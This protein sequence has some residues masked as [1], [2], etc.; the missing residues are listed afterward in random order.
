MLTI[1][2]VIVTF[3]TI[4]RAGIF[5]REDFIDDTWKDRWIQSKHKSDYGEFKLALGRDFNNEKLDRGIQTSKNASFYALSAKFPDAFSNRNRTIAV[6]F[7]VKH[8][9]NI[10]CGGGYI[11]ILPSDVDLNDFHGETPYYIMFGPDICGGDAHVHL[12]FNYK[13]KNLP[14][15]NKLLIVKDDI[16]HLYTLLLKPDK[17]YEILIDGK[18]E[19]EGKLEE[20]WDFLPPK[21]IKDPAASKPKNWDDR[22]YIDDVN[23]KKPDDWDKPEHIKDPDAKKPEDWDEDM[24]GEWEPPMINNPEYKGEWKPKQIKNPKYQGIWEHPEIDNPNYKYDPEI[25]IYEDWGA[26][27]FD[28]WQ[29]KAGSIFDNIVITDN[30]IEAKV[31]AAGTFDQLTVVE[32]YKKKMRDDEKR[33]E[34]EER[35]KKKEEEQQKKE[36]GVEEETHKKDEDETKKS[37]EKKVAKEEKKE[38]EEKKKEEK[39]SEERM[40]EEKDEL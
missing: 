2:S 14:M 36:K 31:F 7:T 22:E 35:I 20:D 16:T 11:K 30:P 15:K 23:D 34:E 32:K 8:D 6:Q 4:S 19:R 21:K 5:F 9:Q 29:V 13:G 28:L 39:T 10:D 18:K 25:G 1:L 38:R 27:G 33:K 37:E 17:Q 12:I 24:D 40:E 3:F 26:I